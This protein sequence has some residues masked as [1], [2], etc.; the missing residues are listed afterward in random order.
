MEIYKEF[1]S[2]FVLFVKRMYREFE[3]GFGVW[4]VYEYVFCV[5]YRIGFF[6]LSFLFNIYKYLSYVC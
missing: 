5:E 2:F 6:R 1:N 4:G 3:V